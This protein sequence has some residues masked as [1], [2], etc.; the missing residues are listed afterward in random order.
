M[1]NGISLLGDF[2]LGRPHRRITGWSFTVL[3]GHSRKDGM[4]GTLSALHNQDGDG[5]PALLLGK[6]APHSR[7]DP[8]FGLPAFYASAPRQPPTDNIAS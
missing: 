6:K 8:L 4:P 2:F 1:W 3:A 7:P 5:Q